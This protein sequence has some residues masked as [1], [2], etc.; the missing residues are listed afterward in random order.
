MPPANLDD[1]H[2]ARLRDHYARHGTL[3]SYAG[4]GQVV[5]FKAKNAAVKL[6]A[7]T[8]LLLLSC[9]HHGGRVDLPNNPMSRWHNV[10]RQRTWRLRFHITP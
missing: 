2:L 10:P 4:M 5:G 1:R 9:L 3:P 8:G 7:K 6:A